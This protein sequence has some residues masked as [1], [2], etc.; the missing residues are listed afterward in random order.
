MRS[1]R[2]LVLA[3]SSA[4]VFA[5]GCASDDVRNEREREADRAVLRLTEV[6]AERDQ[7]HAEL[8]ELKASLAAAQKSESEATAKLKT[9]E[10]ELAKL[11]AEQARTQASAAD[12]AELQKQLEQTRKELE[13]AQEQS[14][15]LHARIETLE[16]QNKA[17]ELQ[18][19]TPAAPTT[20]PN[21]N[22]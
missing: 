11:R 14:K 4:M 18:A 6:Q 19:A 5:V 9:S 13:T 2:W 3:V 17:L 22:K 10:Q 16:T 7:Y 15:A 21:L 1:T 8:E 20:Q 12:A